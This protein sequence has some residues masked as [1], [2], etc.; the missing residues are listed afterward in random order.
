MYLVQ[1][2]YAS[3]RDSREGGGGTWAECDDSENA[4]GLFQYI[5]FRGWPVLPGGI[6]GSTLLAN[7]VQILIAQLT[8]LAENLCH[9]C[10][11]W[12]INIL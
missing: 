9:K 11:Y 10:G 4:S 12:I 2:A 1:P 3:W 5:P 8:G 6:E 7:G